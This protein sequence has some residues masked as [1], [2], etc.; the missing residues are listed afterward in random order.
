MKKNLFSG[1]LLTALTVVSF[2]QTTLY[3]QNFSGSL[4]GCVSVDNNG[5]AGAWTFS[6]NPIASP[7]YGNETFG[8]P[9]ASNG[10]ALILS[11]GN[12]SAVNTDLITPAFDCSSNQYIAL[13]FYQFLAVYSGAVA[14]V[15]ISTDSA[16]WTQIYDAVQSSY[17]TDPE[18][19]QLNI[20][21][22]AANQP[23]VWLKFN[24][25]GNNDLWWAVDDINVVSLVANDVSVDSVVIPDYAGQ[26]SSQP[27]Q[28]TVTNHGG[29]TL[30]SVQLTY[31]IGNAAP[32]TQTFTG[33]SVQTFTST[34][35]QF[36]NQ[37]SLDSVAAYAV[38][39]ASTLPN[40]SADVNLANDSASKKIVAI[41]HIP[42]KNV[43]FEE[44]S[45]IICGYCPGGLTKI[46]EIEAS[47][48]SSFF[49]PV[50]LHAGF[51]TDVM[52]TPDDN[53]L[54]AAF[55]DAAPTANIDRQKFEGNSIVALGVSG[56]GSGSNEWQQAVEAEH[57]VLPPVSIAAYNTFDSATRVL[58][59]TVRSTFYGPA[60][61]NF[62]M[63]CYIVEDSVTGPGANYAQHSY[64]YSSPTTN[65]PWLNVGTYSSSNGY[66]SIAG[67]VQH[68]VERKLMNGVWGTASS[69]GNIPATTTDGGTYTQT[70]TYTLPSA[71]RTKFI[72]LVA[73]VNEYSTNYTSEKNVVLNAVS[74]KLNSA[75]STTAV[76]IAT[77]INEVT[78]NDFSKI[79]LY[80]NPAK[81][82]VTLAYTLENDAKLS[83]EL[84]N[85]VGQLVSVQGQSNYNR[86]SYSTTLNTA[87]LS[88]GLYFVSIK[89][90]NKVVQTLKFVIAK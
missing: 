31:T 19:V 78:P 88:N 36:T 79:T 24:Y 86:G 60:S 40:A 9:S 83:F 43:L 27:I 46:E 75:D 18:L 33:L 30:S 82:L 42:N 73:F 29:Q 50:S 71:W 26:H 87:Q 48:D 66:A 13:K 12:T 84:Y 55:T 67:Y 53:T 63:N 72:K 74:M 52:T 16:N 28:A 3:S 21:S 38:K 80:P 41:S 23:K 10:F 37:P 64:Y 54:A 81:D 47:A 61:G 11:D 69:T 7:S 59:V 62:K 89:D 44:F 6:H 2:A 17:E 51:G 20:S 45:T 34:T 85:M 25:Q 90:E 56:I 70:Y 35:L 14:T 5:T 1:L 77:G 4:N 32:V 58:S 22:Y 39:V 76:A 57:T 65:N 68:H 15:S 8:S 49:I